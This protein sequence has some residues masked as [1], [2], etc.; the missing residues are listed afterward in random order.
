VDKDY[1]NTI[2]ISQVSTQPTLMLSFYL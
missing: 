1:Q 2:P